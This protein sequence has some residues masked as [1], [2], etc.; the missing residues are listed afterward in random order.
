MI[1]LA[2]NRG[3]KNQNGEY[4]TDFIPCVLWRGVAENAAEYC[5]KGDLIG[6]RGRLET[7][8]Y[9]N[10]EKKIREKKKND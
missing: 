8:K 9:E 10:E 1:T 3:Y 6:I 5:H 4:D 2:V 7:R